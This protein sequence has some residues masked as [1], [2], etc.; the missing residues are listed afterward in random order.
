MTHPTDSG[1][2]ARGS[3][4]WRLR[5]R[6]YAYVVPDTP[7]AV[8]ETLCIAQARIRQSGLDQHRIDSDCAL[9]GRLID[10]CDRMRPLGPGGKHD[11][12]HTPDC[13]C[14]PDVRDR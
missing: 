8:R 2:Y 9:L 5:R 1:S 13:G 4:A 7:K 12:R 10:E 14:D 3:L 11:D 6:F